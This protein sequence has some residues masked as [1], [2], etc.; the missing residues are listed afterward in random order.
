MCFAASSATSSGRASASAIA[1]AAA[2]RAW[3]F[4]S[5]SSLPWP[6]C[7]TAGNAACTTFPRIIAAFCPDATNRLSGVRPVRV[8]NDQAPLPG[9]EPRLP[10][11]EM[12]GRELVRP[13]SERGGG[14]FEPA[15][16]IGPGALEI[17]PRLRA[18]RRLQSRP[19]RSS[20]V[21]TDLEDPPAKDGLIAARACDATNE[22]ICV[23][24]R[25]DRRAGRGALAHELRRGAHGTLPGRHRDGPVLPR[26]G[27]SRRQT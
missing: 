22:A 9:D 1:S 15:R 20:I 6:L 25:I 7:Q 12:V 5:S 26:L 4:A 10:P 24:H 17:E 3:A 2:A 27:R 16:E 14:F 19:G 11:L 23:R 18:L 21:P 8:E 13:G